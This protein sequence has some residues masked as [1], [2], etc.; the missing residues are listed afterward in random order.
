M[1]NVESNIHYCTIPVVVNQGSKVLNASSFFLKTEVKFDDIVENNCNV[2]GDLTILHLTALD[3][4]DNE[5]QAWVG[6]V[7]NVSGC[8]KCFITSTPLYNTFSA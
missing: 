8:F 1:S 7:S 5:G 6:Q 4:R 3:S 2:P